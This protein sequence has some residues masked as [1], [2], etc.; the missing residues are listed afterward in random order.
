MSM[1]SFHSSSGGFDYLGFRKAQ[2]GGYE[3]IYD[4][5]VKRRLVWKVRAGTRVKETQLGD[6][7]KTAVNQ[8]KVLPALYSELKKRGV[9]IEAV[10]AG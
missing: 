7:L 1:S 8:P 2:S 6:A 5:G 3:I 9:A 10:V 4:D